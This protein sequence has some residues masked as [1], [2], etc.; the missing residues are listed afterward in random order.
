MHDHVYNCGQPRK[1]R[2]IYTTLCVMISTF[3]FWWG[4]WWDA[5]HGQPINH[6]PIRLTNTNQNL[7]LLNQESSSGFNTMSSA[8]DGSPFDVKAFDIALLPAKASTH[9]DAPGF[10]KATANSIMILRSWTGMP[11]GLEG[12]AGSLGI[13]SLLR[14]SGSSSA[15]TIL[16]PFD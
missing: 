11:P 4:V 5:V 8:T 14:F 13:V 12:R 10:W 1:K 6:I 3:F 9:V 15:R 16:G 7:Y 2:S